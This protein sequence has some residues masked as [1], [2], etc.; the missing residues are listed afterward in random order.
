MGSG[1]PPCRGLQ[2]KRE[3]F[4]V[5]G[6]SPGLPAATAVSP[7]VTE[8][9]SP[10]S[11]RRFPGQGQSGHPSA[12]RRPQSPTP[13]PVSGCGSPSSWSLPRTQRATLAPFGF[14]T[15]PTPP[16]PLRGSANAQPLSWMRIPGQRGRGWFPP[17]GCQRDVPP[18][19]T[20]SSV[21]IRGDELPV[22]AV[23]RCEH[24]VIK[25]PALIPGTRAK[26]LRG[27][28]SKCRSQLLKP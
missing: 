3:D 1:H 5:T 10:A 8:P 20:L 19:A 16:H 13:R 9:R 17:R 27:P 28:A 23:N 18:K 2:P 26:Q 14:P 12:G 22:A 11:G 6:G 15:P 24:L 4:S 21:R 25:S 7:R